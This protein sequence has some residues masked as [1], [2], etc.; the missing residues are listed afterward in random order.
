VSCR[1]RQ[2]RNDQDNVRTEGA[3]NSEPVGIRGKK[4]LESLLTKLYAWV[5]HQE[6]LRKSERPPNPTYLKLSSL[7]EPEE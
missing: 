4:V 6:E 1:F 7:S 3:K 5:E 2:V